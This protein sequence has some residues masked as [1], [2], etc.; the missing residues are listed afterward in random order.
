MGKSINIHTNVKVEKKRHNTI[1]VYKNYSQTMK[2]FIIPQNL[3]KL[4][5]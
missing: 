5:K 1:K 3:G 4:P 2:Q